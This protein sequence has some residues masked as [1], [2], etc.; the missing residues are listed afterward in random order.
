MAKSRFKDTLIRIAEGKASSLGKATNKTLSWG[1]FVNSLARPTRTRESFKQFLKLPKAEQDKLKALDGWLLGGPVQSGRRRKNQILERDLVTLDLDKITAQQYRSI[2]VGKNPI[3]Q[4]EFVAHTTRKHT[5][6]NPRLRIYML[7]KRPVKAEEY[8]ALSRIIAHKVDESMDAVDE[9]S[10]RIAQMMFR[11]TCAQDQKF[12]VWHNAGERIGPDETFQDFKLDWRDY[13][14]LPFSEKRGKRRPSADKAENPT[15][16]RGVIGAF[17]RA[18]SVEEAISEFLSDVY[19]PGDDNS[20][21]PRYSYIPGSTTNGVVVED[22]GLFIYSHHGTDP[23]GDQLC[24]AFDMV[25]LHLYGEEDEGRDPDQPITKAP[26]YEKMV[27]FA[28]GQKPVS[29]ELV[30][31]NYHFL[32]NVDEDLEDLSEQEPDEASSDQGQGLPPSRTPPPKATKKD[33][34]LTEL[35]IDEHGFIKNTPANIRKLLQYDTRLRG[36]M[37]FNELTQCVVMRRDLVTGVEGLRDFVVQDTLNG[38]EWTDLHDRVLRDMFSERREDH[39]GFALK[40]A[41][42]DIRD[43]VDVV[44]DQWRFNPVI[45]YLE[46]LPQWDGVDR[47]LFI[48]YVGTP[49]NPY[50]RDAGEIFLR[51]A[52]AR[53]YNPGHE[54]Q[55][56]PIVQ[57]KQE[58]GKSSIVGSLFGD[59]WGGEL[60]ADLKS[61]AEAVQQMEGFWGMEF[62]EIANLRRSE[63]DDAKTF[64]TLKKDKVR[65][66]YG[67]RMQTYGRRCVYLGTTNQVQFLKDP[68]GNR[69]YW[70]VPVCMPFVDNPGIQRDRDQIWAQALA[71][72]KAAAEETGDYRRIKLNLYGRAKE[73]ALSMQSSHEEEMSEHV[74]A[75]SIES[76]LVQPMKLSDFLAD[77]TVRELDDLTETEDV[78]VLRTKVCAP[79]IDADSGLLIRESESQKPKRIA[80]AMNFVPGWQRLQNPVKFDHPYGR[81]RGWHLIG[82]SKK[83]IQ[84]GYKIVESPKARKSPLDLL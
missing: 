2:R 1:N 54:W 64:V 26:S 23:C 74:L 15:T 51:A 32:A 44:A 79:M 66:P 81:Q 6:E 67:H 68:T 43:A 52:I 63:N 82:A 19:A 12:K 59:H 36:V 3:C 30:E 9:V 76:W 42:E 47:P 25:R 37:A 75:G 77:S 5:E 33:W 35:E 4:Y 31:S 28:K 10:F 21:K 50:F 65:K 72:Y 16:K 34:H 62:P 22:D 83:E 45:E 27:A 17:C 84:Q 60:T 8:S 18:Y 14:N 69:R 70:P 38:D 73:I 58:S 7:P 39:N 57:G 40:P 48:K 49:D 61:N 46:K 11:P 53:A 71:G 80:T 24:N 78:W 13:N 55:F 29:K 20:G 41:R 56:V